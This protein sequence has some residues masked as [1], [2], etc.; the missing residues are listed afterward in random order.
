MTLLMCCHSAFRSCCLHSH[1][2]FLYMDHLLVFLA[3]LKSLAFRLSTHLTSRVIQGTERFDV[4]S[5]VGM[6]AL[7]AKNR[8]FLKV[9]QRSWIDD[10]LLY[11]RTISAES[12][13]MFLFSSSQLALQ[14]RRLFLGFCLA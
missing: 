10:P 7:M 9:S 5:F 11:R 12:S 8:S 3:F 14:N 2:H 1:W 6:L 13:M 4:F